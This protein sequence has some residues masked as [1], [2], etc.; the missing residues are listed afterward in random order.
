MMPH[1]RNWEM[2]SYISLLTYEL[3]RVEASLL[4]VPL[5]TLVSSTDLAYKFPAAV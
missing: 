5:K 2:Q 4:I 3:K 1:V